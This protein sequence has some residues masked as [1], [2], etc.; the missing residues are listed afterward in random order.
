[1]VILH[2]GSLFRFYLGGLGSN[3]LEVLSSLQPGSGRRIRGICS[4]AHPSIRG[5]GLVCLL[6]ATRYPAKASTSFRFGLAFRL[7]RR[8][9]VCRRGGPVD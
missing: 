7:P 1:M 8:L 4:C 3:G 9:F 6:R 5:L 2:L